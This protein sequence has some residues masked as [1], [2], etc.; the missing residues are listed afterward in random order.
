MSRAIHK[1]NARRV[2]TEKRVGKHSDGGGLWLFI[3]K[4]GSKRWVFAYE[5]NK[6]RHEMGLGP[7]AE[8]GLGKAR[9]LAAAARQ[10]LADGLDPLEAR[11][12]AEAEAIEAA[13]VAEL[14]RTGPMLFGT[15]ADDYIDTHEE[16]WKNPKHR[17]QWRN[18]IKT[19]AAAL[20]EKPVQDIS[21]DDVVAVLKPI[22][23]T[24]P[25]T[26]S[27][28]RGRIENILDAAKVGKHIQSP[29]ENPA[30]WRSTSTT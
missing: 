9:D 14:E 1:L 6:K 23:R 29:W 22:W 10:L 20:L 15:F 26:A 8:I 12:M 27:R 13:R 3:T 30:R 25:E 18:T 24:V 16:G 21:T 19:H 2:E 5:R 11:R 28:L 4:D 7:M 17:Q